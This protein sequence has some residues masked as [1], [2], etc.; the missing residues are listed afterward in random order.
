M[1]DYVKKV[2]EE[3]H[4]R[5]GSAN[6]AEGGEEGNKSLFYLTLIIHAN[7]FLQLF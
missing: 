4:F 7:S 2:I 3:L 5:K 6:P 1:K